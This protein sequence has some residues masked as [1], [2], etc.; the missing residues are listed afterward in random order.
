MYI[1][2]CRITLSI[3]IILSIKNFLVAKCALTLIKWK[4]YKNIANNVSTN[5]IIFK[6]Y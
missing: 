4:R 1:Q 3:S 5:T 2:A 6:Y